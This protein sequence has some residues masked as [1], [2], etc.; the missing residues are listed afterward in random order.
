MNIPPIVE[1]A[2]DGA[3]LAVGGGV[4]AMCLKHAD[5][6]CASAGPAAHVGAAAGQDAQ[7]MESLPRGVRQTLPLL[8]RRGE[9]NGREVAALALID[10]LLVVRAHNTALHLAV[11]EASAIHGLVLLELALLL[12]VIYM[13]KQTRNLAVE[14]HRLPILEGLL[15]HGPLTIVWKTRRL[16]RHDGAHVHLEHRVRTVSL[17]LAV[18]GRAAHA[19]DRD[20][21]FLGELLQEV[22]G[23]R[24]PVLRTA[25]IRQLPKGARVL[26]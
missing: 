8:L 10:V 18:T 7:V 26:E 2:P 20:L 15:L 1:I 11:G 19:V 21:V 6:G 3:Q 5:T 13:V 14:A 12:L 22:H 23:A 25:T 24:A 4:A 16:H 17:A 9:L